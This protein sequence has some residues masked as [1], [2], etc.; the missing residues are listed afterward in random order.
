[1]LC[2]QHFCAAVYG[3]LPNQATVLVALGRSSDVSC[4]R[5][6]EVVEKS[7][8][9]GQVILVKGKYKTLLEGQVKFWTADCLRHATY[10]EL[11]VPR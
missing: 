3:G 10:F 6:D 1:M 8:L 7:R 5:S 9:G 2:R 11:I 4:G